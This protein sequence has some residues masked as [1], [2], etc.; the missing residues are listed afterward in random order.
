MIFR[1]PATG[2]PPSEKEKKMSFKFTIRTMVAGAI[3]LAAS[4][5]AVAAT[6][7]TTLSVNATVPATCTITTS[8]V[9][10]GAI[11]TLSATPDDS[12]GTISVTCT[13]GTPWAAS[14]GAGTGTGATL[15]VRKMVSGA[16]LIN[17]A[18]YTNSARTTIWGDGVAPTATIAA[19]GTGSVQAN[20]IYG[21][22]PTGQ[23]STPV[24]SY[25]DTVAVT[26]TF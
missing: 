6:A 9:A 16:N 5:P 24:G 13:N 14:A 1:D 19:T 11:D 20:T 2:Q 18:L 15:S 25:A 12:T 4:A 22:V 10:F 17:Y 3:A 8:A 21:R 23:G 26:V 7:T